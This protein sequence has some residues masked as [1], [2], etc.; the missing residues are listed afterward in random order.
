MRG[1]MTSWARTN[2]RGRVW[3]RCWEGRPPRKLVPLHVVLHPAPPLPLDTIGGGRVHLQ[4]RHLVLGLA[5]SSG[6]VAANPAGQVPHREPVSV[7]GLH[8][9]NISYEG[10]ELLLEPLCK[11]KSHFGEPS[12]W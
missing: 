8:V 7:A 11:S 9:R 1:A 3:V 2:L 10:P 12:A 4:A 6:V 5:S